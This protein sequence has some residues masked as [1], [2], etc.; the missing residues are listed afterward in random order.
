ME[1]VVEG[2]ETSAT[3]DEPFPPDVYTSAVALQANLVIHLSALILLARKP[4]LTQ[5]HGAAR[6]LLSRSWHAQKITRMAVW[7]D[8]DEQW[9]PIVAAALLLV[10]REMTHASQQ[11]A[12]SSCFDRMMNAT[13]IPLEED[14]NSLRLYWRYASGQDTPPSDILRP[15]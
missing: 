2:S 4:R 12:I 11:Q 5:A 14:I 8:F 13:Q 9:D 10:S 15:I 6:I 3:E 1:P 7:N